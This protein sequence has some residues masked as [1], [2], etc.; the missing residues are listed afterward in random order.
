MLF[1]S[2]TKR[3]IFI[4]NFNL[5]IID[6]YTDSTQ[7]DI[8]GNGYQVP[9]PVWE[10]IN[11]KKASI[12]IRV[13]Q[14][15]LNNNYTPGEYN[16]TF[17]FTKKQH[18][19]THSF[20][21]FKKRAFLW[22]R[23][24]EVPL[25]VWYLGNHWTEFVSNWLFLF[26]LSFYIFSE[27]LKELP[28]LKNQKQNVFRK[29]NIEKIAFFDFGPEVEHVNYFRPFQAKFSRFRHLW[30]VNFSTY[31]A[32]LSPGSKDVLPGVKPYFGLFDEP[33][34]ALPVSGLSY[35]IVLD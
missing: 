5:L 24:L 32:D 34:R 1:F 2:Q 28:T 12:T 9:L 20:W 19:K 7:L 14:I 31:E 16:P 35:K 22:W 10:R 33:S 27:I 3:Y 6:V 18:R 13:T 15:M 4:E 17:G 8:A 26:V 29:K 25:K 23:V 21:M 11:K 30:G